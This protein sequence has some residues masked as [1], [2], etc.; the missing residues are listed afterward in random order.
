VKLDNPRGSYYGGK[1][2][3]PVTKAVI[4]TALAA[5]DASL[6]WGELTS[7]RVA[8][9]PP[10]GDSAP[11]TSKKVLA[12]TPSAIEVASGT[13]SVDSAAVATR[14]PLID[15]TPEPEPAPP[16]SFQL[17]RPPKEAAVVTKVVNVP[18]VGGLPL[19]VA[20]R[21]LHRAGFR[22]QLTDGARGTTPPAGAALRTG[23]VVRLAHQ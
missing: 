9:L 12:P 5:R 17:S 2:A 7:Q 3:A 11:A 18:D 6:E 16:S 22:V 20:V 4:E 13:V 10:A 23:S 15:S 21:E 1:T 14:V 8:Y 19:R